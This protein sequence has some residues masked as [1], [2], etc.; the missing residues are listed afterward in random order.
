MLHDFATPIDIRDAGHGGGGAERRSARRLGELRDAVSKHARDPIAQPAK[1]PNTH[2][3]KGTSVR[4]TDKIR[5]A[6]ANPV[7][8]VAWYRQSGSPRR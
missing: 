4:Q 6:S 7:S 5:A 8:A 1:L 2:A 3:R